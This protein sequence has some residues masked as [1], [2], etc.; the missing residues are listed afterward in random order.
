MWTPQRNIIRPTKGLII[1]V[2]YEDVILGNLAVFI[3]GRG[4]YGVS[5]N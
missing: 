4:I 1:F 3:N 5:K 2:A